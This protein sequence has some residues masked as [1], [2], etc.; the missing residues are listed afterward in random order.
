M[1]ENEIQFL[2]DDLM[3]LYTVVINSQ[4]IIEGINNDVLRRQYYLELYDV[5]QSVNVIEGYLK[6]LIEQELR[7]NTV[8]NLNYYKI[9]KKLNEKI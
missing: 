3:H 7:E 4:K 9:L 2:L 5:I 6:S 8:T 1:R